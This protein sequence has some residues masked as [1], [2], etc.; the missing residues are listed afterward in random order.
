MA[1]KGHMLRGQ[2]FLW[3]FWYRIFQLKGP[4]AFQLVSRKGAGGAG[5]QAA[6]PAT[7][8]SGQAR[9]GQLGTFLPSLFSLSYWSLG[10]VTGT[11]PMLLKDSYCSCTSWAS[12][13]SAQVPVLCTCQA[14]SKHSYMGQSSCAGEAQPPQSMPQN[15]A[16]KDKDIRD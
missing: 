11:T 5:I 12:C 7:V 2:S 9:P 10:W 1:R 4:T 13:N 15:P 8:Y 14:P 3:R 6:T 16:T